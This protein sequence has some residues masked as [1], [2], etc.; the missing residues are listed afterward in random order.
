MT[1]IFEK[2]LNLLNI[3]VSGGIGRRTERTF[4]SSPFLLSL[5]YSVLRVNESAPGRSKAD[6]ASDAGGGGGGEA[7]VLL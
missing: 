5:C 3:V 4:H 6:L 7:S 2:F 1:Q